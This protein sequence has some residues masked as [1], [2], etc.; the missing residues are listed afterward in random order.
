M[1]RL[2]PIDDP[3]SQVVHPKTVMVA[4]KQEPKPGLR[5]GEHRGD[6]RHDTRQGVHL[7]T[8][9]NVRLTE[10]GR[11]GRN[12]NNVQAEDLVG[13]RVVPMA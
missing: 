1:A 4:R 13:T 11:H 8:R 12:A 6:V 5:D 10:R 2:K 7:D 9:S 3:V